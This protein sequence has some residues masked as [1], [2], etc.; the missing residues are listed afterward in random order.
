MQLAS[1]M[2]ELEDAD[3][4]SAL[5]VL[6]RWIHVVAVVLYIGLSFF[7]AWIYAPFAKELTA[8]TKSLVNTALLPRVLFF[9]RF[10]ALYALAFGLLLLFDFY[11]MTGNYFYRP[12]TEFAGSKPA[13]GVWMQPFFML[14]LGYGLYELLVSKFFRRLPALAAI[15]WAASAT[16]F[17]GYLI[18]VL[19]ASHRCAMVH[20]AALFG[21]VMVANTWMYIWPAHLRALI[22][23]RKHA[24]PPLPELALATERARHNVYLAVPAILLMLS[25]HISWL[26]GIEDW[27]LL[28]AI[29]FAISFAATNLLFRKASHLDE[30]HWIV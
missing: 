30:E 19:G 15:T 4:M 2:L 11:Y 28:L 1:L 9:Y 5:D 7:L 24:S 22:A 17:A 13:T 12:L 6:F 27:Y 3:V 29:V 20:V 21:T 16:G 23:C 26:T 18:E 14:L 25:V 10:A 8:N